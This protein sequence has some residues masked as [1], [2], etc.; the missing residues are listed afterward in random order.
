LPVFHILLSLLDLE[1][2]PTAARGGRDSALL[3][4]QTAI[5]VLS[6][7]VR[8]SALPM[9]GAIVLAWL[10]IAWRARRDLSR[11]WGLLRK[12]AVVGLVSCGVTAAIAASVPG[13]YLSQGR[14]G[15]VIWQ[16][17]T[18][19]LGANPAFP[20]PGVNDM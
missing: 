15:T 18:Q 1:P 16:R 7:L 8:G 11:L 3:G 2:S 4:V 9:I 19:S 17:I 10:A 6:I 5:L 14:F 12:L 20:F 13:E